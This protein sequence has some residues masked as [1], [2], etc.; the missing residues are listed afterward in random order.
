LTDSN[1]DEEPFFL[2]TFEPPDPYDSPKV[3]AP[4]PEP[5]KN[6]GGAP[7]GNTNALK[8]GFYSRHFK[9]RELKDLDCET[10][11]DDEIKFVRVCIRRISEQAENITSLD[12]GL[13][14]LRAISHAAYTIT[15]M[16]K[17]RKGIGSTHTYEDLLLMSLSDAVDTISKERGYKF[18]PQPQ[19]P[20][21]R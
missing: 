2:P 6:K 20:P 8:H 16:V 17:I 7:R 14:Y 5:K 12:Q 13:E 21:S 1:P 4:S 19:I 3:P 15:R 10:D 18:G 11:L 9:T